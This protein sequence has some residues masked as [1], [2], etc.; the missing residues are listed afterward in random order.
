LNRIQREGA[1]IVRISYA[2]VIEIRNLRMGLEMAMHQQVLLA[3]LFRFMGVL[4]RSQRQS[5]D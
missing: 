5:R 2:L 1:V 4:G 3:V